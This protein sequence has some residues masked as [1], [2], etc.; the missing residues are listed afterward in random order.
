M[1]SIKE[2]VKADVSEPYHCAATAVVTMW[3]TPPPP[4]PLSSACFLGRLI[5]RPL[6]H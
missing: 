5:Y 2:A 6:S 4:P 1:G 3:S